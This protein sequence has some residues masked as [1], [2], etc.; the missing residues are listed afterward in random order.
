[1]NTNSAKTK[2][3]LL[4]TILKVAVLLVI[5]ILLYNKLQSEEKIFER[6]GVELLKSIDQK[7]MIYLIVIIL[8]P[9]NWLIEALKWRFLVKK[10]NQIS[11]KE[12]F[13]GVLA[14][15][16]LSFATPHGLGDY[17]GRILSLNSEGREGL[18][19]SLLI[20]RASQ[21]LATALFGLIGLQYLFGLWW[22]MSG[23]VICFG[24]VILCFRI[25]H[26]LHNFSKIEKYVSLID[27][28]SKSEL[29]YIQM[30]SI[31]RY[32]IFSI[33]FLLV[34]YI[35]LP[36][37]NLD[38]AY[39]GV[40]YIFLTKSVLPTFNFLSDLGI[41]EYAAIQYFEKFSI[42][43]VSIVAASLSLWV[44]NI[45][46]PTIIGIPSMLKLKWNNT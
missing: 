14:G 7:W 27:T 40:T 31:C 16:T 19:G 24:F 34:I 36:E 41:R 10:L 38:I 21:M 28:Y 4:V 1:M 44:I 8:M 39:G 2:Y 13:R 33:Q 23:F 17:F 25:V 29:A 46:L 22:V 3:S 5:G 20:S 9:F 26:W 32:L 37:I 11:I 15:L 43:T 45:L 35:Y 18:V 30:L 6:I 12:A 42:E